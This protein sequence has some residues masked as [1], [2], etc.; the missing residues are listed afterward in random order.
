MKVEEMKTIGVL[1]EQKQNIA[2]DLS[3]NESSDGGGNCSAGIYEVRAVLGRCHCVS[4][5]G[6]FT[7]YLV[8]SRFNGKRWHTRLPSRLTE[9]FVTMCS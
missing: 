7:S 6:T 2:F 1:E 3:W 5:R 8:V 9:E 4:C